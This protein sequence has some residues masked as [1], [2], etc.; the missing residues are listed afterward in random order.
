MRRASLASVA[1]SGRFY[2]FLGLKLGSG[3]L[4]A[5]AQRGLH[6]QRYL[7]QATGPRDITQIGHILYTLRDMIFIGIYR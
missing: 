7:A 1:I 5:Y 3:V 4:S 2:C 6:R